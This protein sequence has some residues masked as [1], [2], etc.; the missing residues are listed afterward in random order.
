MPPSSHEPIE[1]PTLAGYTI[2][3]ASGQAQD[4]LVG[5]RSLEAYER[6]QSRGAGPAR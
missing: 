2:D 4:W 3:V 5:E 6:L 1:G